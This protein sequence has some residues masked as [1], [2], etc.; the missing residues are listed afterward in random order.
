M[1]N[2]KL[3]RSATT[4]LAMLGLMLAGPLTSSAFACPMC[5]AA[6]E[7]DDAKPRAYMYSIIFM[8]TMPG[9]M[10]GGMTIGL[11]KLGRRESQAVDQSDLNYPSSAD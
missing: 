4:L 9:M 8:L 5:K 6:N 11:V 3:R 1:K 7:E 2:S 10:V